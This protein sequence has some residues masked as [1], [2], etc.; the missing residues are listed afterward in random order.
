MKDN[1]HTVLTRPVKIRGKIRKVEAEIE[2]LRLSI[3]PGAMRYDK[4]SVQ[5]GKTTD[6]MSVFA[7][8]LDEL[9]RKLGNLRLQYLDAQETI[10]QLTSQLEDPED[11]IITLRFLSGLSMDDVAVKISMSR[12]QTYRHYSKAIKKLDDVCESLYIVNE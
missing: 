6:P 5:G 1:T 9:E 10:T 8:K 2:A 11:V 7:S 4:D 12:A 3:L